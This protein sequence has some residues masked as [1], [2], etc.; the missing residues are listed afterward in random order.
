MRDVLPSGVYARFIEGVWSEDGSFAPREMVE[1]CV[2]THLTTWAGPGPEHGGLD[3]GLRKH[4]SALAWGH[5][6]GGRF[7]LDGCAV[8]RPGEQ[9]GGEVLLEDVA[10]SVRRLAGGFPLHRVLADP[11]QA[12]HL[13][14]TL[15]GIVPI[16]EFA[17]ATANQVKL[18]MSFYEGLSKQLIVL[19]A[20]LPDLVDEIADLD[21]VPSGFGF[22]FNSTS[23]EY[24]H[25]DRAVAV[26]LSYYSAVT[27]GLDA[28][29]L[30][31][32]V[33]QIRLGGERVSAG[34]P[35]GY[36]QHGGQSQE[37]WFDRVQEGPGGAFAAGLRLKSE[38]PSPWD[39][40]GGD[41]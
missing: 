19:P 25:G 23:G 27:L 34:G 24:G 36:G 16:E 12:M 8:W 26:A 28:P 5:P 11:F 21:C 30:E 20:D 10:E 17:F 31:E 13:I 32:L 38:W 4:F 14:Q 1:R 33:A 29:T 39:L 15:R 37:T 3:I 9:E 18:A 2:G 41:E 22:R 35:T 7:L 6:T 40:E